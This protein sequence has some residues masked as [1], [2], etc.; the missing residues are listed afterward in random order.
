MKRFFSRPPTLPPLSSY[1]FYP[2]SFLSGSSVDSIHSPRPFL[3]PPISSAPS[4]SSVFTGKIPLSPRSYLTPSSFVYPFY[5]SFFFCRWTSPFL[6][7]PSQSLS[8]IPFSWWPP[9]SRLSSQSLHRL[10]VRPSTQWHH[11][12]SQ[13]SA[14]SGRLSFS[15]GTRQ[16]F[17]RSGRF[18][19]SVG[20]RQTSRSSPS[21]SI[22]SIPL[23]SSF[24]RGWR[25][26]SLCPYSVVISCRSSSPCVSSTSW[27]F[28]VSNFSW[29]P[30]SFEHRYLRWAQVDFLLP[31]FLYLSPF[32][33]FSFLFS[34][35]LFLSFFAAFYSVVF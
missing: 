16:L 27:Q 18:S 35:Y 1:P 28:F 31:F 23:R 11:G 24:H 5:I 20:T 13:F 21:Y 33:P 2:T 19:L 6:Y 26:P 29:W 3:S 9:F 7:I 10:H 17:A 12:L 14:R 15:V 30:R 25:Y 4:V 8:P 34:P 32:V 22:S